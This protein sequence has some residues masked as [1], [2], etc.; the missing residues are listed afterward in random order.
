MFK[1][2]ITRESLATGRPFTRTVTVVRDCDTYRGVAPGRPVYIQ[3][4]P[5]GPE[6]LEILTPAEEATATP[7]A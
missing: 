6:F 2:T 4:G 7:I 5:G 3:N 1:V